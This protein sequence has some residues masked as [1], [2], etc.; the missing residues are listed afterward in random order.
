M[1]KYRLCEALLMLLMLHPSVRADS[2]A[3]SEEMQLLYDECNE[4][5]DEAQQSIF[6]YMGVSNNSKFLSQVDSGL[7]HGGIPCQ[8]VGCCMQV[9]M[10]TPEELE[11]L[12]IVMAWFRKYEDSTNNY[13][14]SELGVLPP[15]QWSEPCSS[16]VYGSCVCTTGM[17]V[18]SNEDILFCLARSQ[19]MQAE[20]DHCVNVVDPDILMQYMN[21]P[22][23]T[24]LV[25]ETNSGFIHGATPCDA[26]GC[27]MQNK[28]SVAFSDPARVGLGVLQWFADDPSQWNSNQQTPTIFPYGGELSPKPWSIALADCVKFAQSGEAHASNLQS[29]VTLHMHAPFYTPIVNKIGHSGYMLGCS[30][31]W[32]PN[33]GDVGEISV[34]FADESMQLLTLSTENAVLKSLQYPHTLHNSGI[35]RLWSDPWTAWKREGDCDKIPTEKQADCRFVP[36]TNPCPTDKPWPLSSGGMSD[37]LT[38][39]NNEFTYPLFYCFSTSDPDDTDGRHMCSYHGPVAGPIF[40][41]DTTGG[42]FIVKPWG[43]LTETCT[44]CDNGIQ[45]IAVCDQTWDTD[46]DTVGDDS[47]LGSCTT[48]AA[49]TNCDLEQWSADSQIIKCDTDANCPVMPDSNVSKAIRAI[50]GGGVWKCEAQPHPCEIQDKVCAFVWEKKDVNEEGAPPTNVTIYTDT[51]LVDQISSY[52]ELS[53]DMCPETNYMSTVV[54]E[55]TTKSPTNEPTTKSPTNEATTKTPTNEPTTKS[56]TNEPTTKTPTNEPTTESLTNE[57]TTEPTD[58]PTVDAAS[59][60]ANIKTSYEGSSCCEKMETTDTNYADC[61]THKASYKSA[62]CCRRKD[63]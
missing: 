52:K 62:L 63:I 30:S 51:Y 28:T 14:N 59:V 3:M 15:K 13:E 5:T 25:D 8:A 38:S 16:S 10:P 34:W 41:V 32:E 12:P 18:S 7:N 35:I 19:E 1:V 44:D 50:Y 49:Y 53:G 39:S 54:G 27:C 11:V 55:S 9:K 24:P 26:N 6:A 43:N 60:C 36:P 58:A 31:L 2:T 21:V 29:Y 42:K 56:P 46:S 4:P 45:Q 33:K 61:A 22:L 47:Q 20:F 40:D 17:G 57:P 37:A 23:S 48:P